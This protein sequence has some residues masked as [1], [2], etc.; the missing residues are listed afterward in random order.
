MKR[1]IILTGGGTSGHVWPL[2]AISKKIS[3]EYEILYLGT[4]SSKER[5][6]VEASGIR[7]KKVFSG[8]LRRYFSFMN[9]IILGVNFGAAFE[10]FPRFNGRL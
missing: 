4:G 10:Y 8:K 3:S 9:F 2:I 7:Y 1:K 6:L 5:E